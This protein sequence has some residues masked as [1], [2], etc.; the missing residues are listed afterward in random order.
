MTNNVPAPRQELSRPARWAFLTL[1]GV[2]LLLGLIGVF[3][4]VMPTV[5]FLIVAAWAASRSSPRLHD[6]LMKHPRW[7]RQLTDWYD[8]GVVPRKAKWI[9][10]VMMS[11]S[12]ISMLVIAPHRFLPW[13]LALIAGMAIVLAWLWRRPEHKPPQA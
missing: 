8:Y 11:G 7:G 1:A 9:T 10:S 13:V 6:W 2:F 5:P 3:V 4:P 12:A